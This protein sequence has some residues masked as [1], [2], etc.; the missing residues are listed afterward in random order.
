[1]ATERSPAR[2][3]DS[4]VGARGAGGGGGAAASRGESGESEDRGPVKDI[5]EVACSKAVFIAQS[6]HIFASP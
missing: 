4:G 6:P 1:M 3:F 2:S 5:G